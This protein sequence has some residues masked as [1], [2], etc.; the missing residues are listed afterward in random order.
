MA[1]LVIDPTRPSKPMDN[2]KGYTHESAKSVDRLVVARRV[3]DGLESVEEVRIQPNIRK[4]I[5]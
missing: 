1:L 3:Q 5:K 2:S 4:A